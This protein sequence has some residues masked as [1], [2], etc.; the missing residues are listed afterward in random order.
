MTN[1]TKN[2]E[3]IQKLSFLNFEEFYC[4]IGPKKLTLIEYKY[5]FTAQYRPK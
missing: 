3:K 2:V 4:R 1:K 5:I